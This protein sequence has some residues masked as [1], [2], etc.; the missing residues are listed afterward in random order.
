MKL[1]NELQQKLICPKTKSKLKHNCDYLESVIDSNIRYPIINGIP[2]LINN[3]KSI[4]SID[5]FI[6]MKDTTFKLN[7]NIIK[8]NNE[9]VHT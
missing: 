8:K 2:V 7:E 9:K 4:F 3:E 6:K 5:D 1:S